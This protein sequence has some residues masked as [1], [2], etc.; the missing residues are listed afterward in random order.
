MPWP[1]IKGSGAADK[2]QELA[3]HEFHYSSLENMPGDADYAYRVLRGHGINGK[4]DGYI[5]KN[6]LANYAHMR[7][8]GNNH[9]AERFIAQVRSVKK[10]FN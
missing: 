2:G 7:N 8:V 10:E 1:A 4:Y 6:L 9:W 5:Y 3:A